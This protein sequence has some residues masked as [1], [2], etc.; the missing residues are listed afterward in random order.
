[1]M[2]IVLYWDETEFMRPVLECS[3]LVARVLMQQVHLIRGP[4]LEKNGM[5]CARA[6]YIDGIDLNEFDPVEDSL[7]IVG[8]SWAIKNARTAESLRSQCQVATLGNAEL[9]QTI[10]HGTL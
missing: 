2:G 7:D 5:N 10:G 4:I 6:H 3:A 8:G 1:M 9:R